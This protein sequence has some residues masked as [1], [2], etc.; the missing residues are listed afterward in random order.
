MTNTMLMWQRKLL[1]CL[2]I[3]PLSRISWTSPRRQ[4]AQSKHKRTV[5]QLMNDIPLSQFLC[6]DVKVNLWD[7][8]PRARTATRTTQHQS[9]F[10]MQNRRARRGTKEI[11]DSLILK[12][13][14]NWKHLVMAGGES[15]P[16]WMSFVHFDGNARIGSVW[17][18]LDLLKQ[19]IT[20]IS[21]CSHKWIIPKIKYLNCFKKISTRKATTPLD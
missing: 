15:G 17:I 12:R 14:I 21:E 8:N 4:D 5:D 16:V 1:H 2:R 11:Q 13:E 19:C 18:P 7:E 10:I 20:L 6:C 3:G 9:G